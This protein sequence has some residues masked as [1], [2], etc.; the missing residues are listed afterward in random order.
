MAKPHC[1]NCKSTS[2]PHSKITGLK[3]ERVLLVYCSECGCMMGAV[4][5]TQK[6]DA[7]SHGGEREDVQ[8]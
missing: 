7:A 6:D 3:G 1:P 2:K 5:Y 4:N 8:D